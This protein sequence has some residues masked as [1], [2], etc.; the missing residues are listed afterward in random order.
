RPVW[1]VGTIGYCF[2]FLYRYGISKKRKRTVD[3]FRLIEKLKSDAPLSD[4]DRKV[5]LYLLSSIKASLEDINYAIIFLLSIAAI[6]A[7][8]ILTAMG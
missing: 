6:V 1:Y 8:L 2:F 7:D 5:I 4:E 3:G